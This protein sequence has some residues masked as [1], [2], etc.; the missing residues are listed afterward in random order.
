MEQ[1]S[2]FAGP[3]D[4]RYSLLKEIKCRGSRLYR[5]T[6][7]K[8]ETALSFVSPLPRVPGVLCSFFHDN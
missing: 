6:V 2:S 1:K 3:C 5:E 7:P 8:A 4:L